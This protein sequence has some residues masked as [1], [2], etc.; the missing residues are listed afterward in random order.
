[1]PV[2]LR[3]VGEQVY[4]RGSGGQNGVMIIKM[5]MQEEMRGGGN[6][7]VMDVSSLFGRR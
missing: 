1:M 6:V 5:R 2:Q 4:G 7:S 3:L